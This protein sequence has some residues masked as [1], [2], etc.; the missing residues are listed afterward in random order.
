MH[1]IASVLPGPVAKVLRCV[2]FKETWEDQINFCPLIGS[3]LE[4]Q[5][6]SNYREVDTGLQTGRENDFMKE[7]SPR[8]P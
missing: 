1:A 5:V 2:T 6:V 4:G 3:R 8:L 7:F